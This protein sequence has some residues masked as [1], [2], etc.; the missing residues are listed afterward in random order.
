MSLSVF[1]EMFIKENLSRKEQVYLHA[2]EMFKDRGYAAT[3]MRD[4][5]NSLG[6]EAASLY[7]HIRSKEELL[8]KICFDIAAEFIG[9]L[10]NVEQKD[11][12]ASE[13][14][15]LGIISHTK[16][17]ARDLASAAVFFNEYRNLSPAYLHDFLLLRI[18]YINRFK[19]M[20]KQGIAD[21]EFAEVD[22]KLAVM[23]MFSSLNWMP[24]WYNHTES[25]DQEK[26]STELAQMLIK[27]LKK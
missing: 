13:K 23:T 4:L 15:R 25:I 18:N 26:V 3:S 14:L 16:V 1:L 5:A 9:G 19:K 24:T 20:I 11:I 2:T 12:P 7:S 8:R 22:I 21:D 27:G 17:I 6:I 10:I